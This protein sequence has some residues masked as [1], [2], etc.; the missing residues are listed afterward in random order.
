VSR[1]PRIRIKLPNQ[2]FEDEIINASNSEV[3]ASN[4]A[5]KN[6]FRGLF[7]EAEQQSGEATMGMFDF[8]NPDANVT[9]YYRNQIQETN[10]EGETVNANRFNE[11]VMNFNGIK[12]N[13]YENEFNVDLSNQNKTEG[14]ENLYLKGGQ[15]SSAVL[16]LFAGPDLDGNGVPDELDELR[17]NQWLINEASI[18]LYLNDDIA[19]SSMN[20][21][22]RVFLF[23]LDDEQ[24][25]ED[26][27]RDPT[28]SENPF[29]S[30]QVH[31]GILREDEDGNPF[32][33][34]RIT[35]FV[36][37]ILN[38]N[39]DNPRLGLYVTSNVNDSNLERTRNFGDNVSSNVHRGMLGTPRGVVIHGNR[40]SNEAK[41]L[42]LRII[43]TE[44]N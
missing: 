38:N 26:F 34:V 43:Y 11:F 20:R 4:N 27:T 35:Y 7:L 24:V 3:L 23:N 32:Y 18:D 42:K 2:Y 33:R 8:N 25:L 31:L 41:K 13:L 1:S 36:N 44:T 14:E 5:F 39:Q 9:I 21:N 10:S 30:R 15:G 28:A 17:E 6:Y 37:N 29:Q 12:M 40:S 22:R 16:Q 19:P